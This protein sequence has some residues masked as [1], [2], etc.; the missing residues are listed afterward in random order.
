MQTAYRFISQSVPYLVPGCYL[1]LLALVLGRMAFIRNYWFDEFFT[2]YLSRDPE[3]LLANLA[4][5]ADLNPPLNYWL[6]SL[7]ITIF[8]ESFLTVRLPAIA[9]TILAH[10]ALFAF[11]RYRRPVTEATLAMIALGIANGVWYYFIEAR[12]YGLL[13]G[14]AA[15]LLLAWQRRWTILFALAAIGIM[16]THY[17]GVVPLAGLAVAE[18]YRARTEKQFWR[19]SLVAFGAAGLTLAACAPLWLPAGAQYA[20]GF[21]AKPKFN[22]AALTDTF[23]KL[24]PVE[25]G[26]PIFLV[27]VLAVIG[28]VWKQPATAGVP[29]EPTEEGEFTRSETLAV[30]LYALGPVL[31]LFIGAKL[32]GGFFHR[33]CLPAELGFAVLLAMLVRRL[34]LGTRWPAWVAGAVLFYFSPVIHW[35]SGPGYFQAE[36]AAITTHAAWLEE[37]APDGTIIFENAFDFTRI[38]HLQPDRNMKPL[39]LMDLEKTRVAN[40]SDTVERG[41]DALRKFSPAPVQEL[42][43]PLAEPLFYAGTPANWRVIE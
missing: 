36:A 4:A 10:G 12:P 33:Y 34:A 17:Y 16:L 1:L 14:F 37:K 22:I 35:N 29:S 8:G 13:L 26:P 3:R 39:Y 27:L 21:W 43:G 9:G 32:A 42:S 2:L 28:G 18:L 24:L 19:G 15:L 5:G 11:V 20:P 31:G 6:T 7:A 25:L 30:M 23:Q 38:W 41:L 40:K